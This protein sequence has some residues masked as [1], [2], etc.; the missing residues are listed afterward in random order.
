MPLSTVAVIEGTNTYDR[1]AT[2]SRER[3]RV[4]SGRP[5]LRLGPVEVARAQ[6]LIDELSRAHSLQHCALFLWDPSVGRLRLAAQHWGA[7]EDLGEV[8]AGAWTISLNGICG[9]AFTSLQPVLVANV[10]DEPAYLGF[11]GSRTCSELVVPFSI[12]G[13]VVGV[14]NLESPRRGAFGPADV[15]TVSAWIESVLGTIRGFYSNPG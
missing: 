13:L 9:R 14:V 8:R 1:R 2:E 15:A 12:D 11:P 5:D 7:G 6:T 3:E 10:D 4:G